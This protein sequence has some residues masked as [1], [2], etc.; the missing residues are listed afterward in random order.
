MRIYLIGMPGAGKT[1]LG[2]IVGEKT[3]LSFLDLDA[4][5]H[6]QLENSPTYLIQNYG[7]ASFRIIEKHFLS[8]I[9]SHIEL[10]SCGGGV[11][12]FFNNLDYLKKTGKV[13]WINT[14]LE[15][16]QH[17]LQAFNHPLFKS[18]FQLYPQLQAMLAYRKQFYE[19]ADII[20]ENP[21]E[22]ELIK[23]LATVA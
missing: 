10:V 1:H 2:K 19:K 17:R 4:F 21:S 23:I 18:T 9:P 22:E 15:V 20:L 8:K 14:S 5:I 3:K 16:I 7:E 11:P 6:E 12:C 13:I